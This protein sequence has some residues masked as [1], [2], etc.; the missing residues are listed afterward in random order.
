MPFTNVVPN[1]LPAQR[2]LNS[3]DQQNVLLVVSLRRGN[4]S[5]NPRDHPRE[6]PREFW[7]CLSAAREPD[8]D[9]DREL[10]DCLSAA[11]ETDKTQLV[12]LGVLIGGEKPGEFV[13]RGPLAR[14]ARTRFRV[15][16]AVTCC[17]GA[18]GGQGCPFFRIT[19][20]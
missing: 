16:C 4:P 19:D 3:V 12:I 11:R 18:R 6:N 7:E 2:A 10:W 9:P 17:V 8:R 13:A 5:E 14:P 20:R 1:E 15:R